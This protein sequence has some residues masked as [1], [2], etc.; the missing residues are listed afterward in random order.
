MADTDNRF[1]IASHILTP[2]TIFIN[3]NAYLKF[4]YFV[5]ELFCAI[6]ERIR[7]GMGSYRADEY[8][9]D[10]VYSRLSGEIISSPVEL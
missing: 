7:R 4:Q 9:F 2:Q 6:T 5:I 1:V 3:K 10:E 8:R